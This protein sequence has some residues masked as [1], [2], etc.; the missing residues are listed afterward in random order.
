MSAPT[1]PYSY[2]RLPAD[3]PTVNPLH[4][5][6]KDGTVLGWIDPSG[7]GHGTLVG[8]PGPAGP[9]G[10]SP[11]STLGIQYAAPW[12]NDSNDGLTWPT[13][14]LTVYGALQALPGGSASPAKAG[15]GSV[16]LSSNTASGNP[17]SNGGLWL[18][19]VN[20]PNYAS[21]PSGWLIQSGPLQ[22]IGA[23]VTTTA[24]HGHKPAS[25]LSWSNIAFQISGSASGLNLSNLFFAYSKARIGIDSNGSRLGTGGCSGIS[26]DNVGFNLGNSPLGAGPGLDIGSN[27][28][29]IYIKDCV[30]SGS[31]GDIFTV[32]A[33]GL[34]RS[35]NVVT[36]TTSATNN[37]Y[38]GQI[39]STC[40]PD[41]SSF[42]GS[43]TVLSVIGSPQTQVTWAQNG[44][45]A[46]SGN[47]YV[48]SDQSFGL[49]INPG[50]TGGGS[51]LIFVENTNVN[52]GG[53]R[54]TPG[55]NGGGIYVRNMDMEGNF[56]NP[57]TSG[58]LITSVNA[59]VIAK[60]DGIEMS[61]V[62][63]FGNVPAVRVD[64]STLS[65]CV[66]V[67][68]VQGGTI[69]VQGAAIVDGQYYN[70]FRN[71]TAGPLQQ[72]QPGIAG[73]RFFGQ[74]D[75]HRR[76]FAPSAVRFTNLAATFP[77]SWTINLPG[78]TGVTIT[79]GV[80]APDGTSG[81]GTASQSGGVANNL[82]FYTGSRSVSVGD[83]LIAGAWVKANTGAP[84]PGIALQ[85]LG[86]GNVVKN[87]SQVPPYTGD[88]EWEFTF[89]VSKITKATTSPA[90]VSVN[91]SFG[92]TTPVTAYGPVFLHISNGT[93]SD[94]EAYELAFA[95]ASYNSAAPVGSIAGMPGQSL[96]EDGLILNAAAPTV[97]SGQLGLGGT[98]AGTASSGA[99]T[100]P[101]NPLG[102]LVANVGGTTVK[103]PYYAS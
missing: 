57:S 22:I 94:N 89:S 6:G 36:A 64:N 59:A 30:L 68:R 47:G 19:G 31:S 69:N 15:T 91:F 20:D 79:T 49:S 25:Y 56:S 58:V 55:V 52:T 1:T 26:L 86:S 16:Y 99:G 38:V 84:A 32:T 53:V 3:D 50:A 85:L 51:G 7:N 35:G 44:P 61:D 97:G 33:N 73:N 8:Q 66:R 21:P 28:F 82:I 14:K 87:F 5:V 13:A 102:F 95:L 88:G 4:I 71:L 70:N 60:I 43:F 10:G 65:D 29:W 24:A 37:F 77:A 42:S 92:T 75:A 54:F 48:I 76:S 41:D 45:D 2:L 67:S 9:A 96:F 90:T 100:L 17:V 80:T 12:G 63:G 39:V 23:G 83:Y 11:P 27:C 74:V 62:G 98:T 34:S 78:N 46:T 81:A 18:L 72:I 101:G 93:I 103:I 40:N